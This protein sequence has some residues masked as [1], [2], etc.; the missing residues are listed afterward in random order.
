M[1]RKPWKSWHQRDCLTR[2]KWNAND[3]V[4]NTNKWPCLIRPHTLMNGVLISGAKIQYMWY[5]LVRPHVAK[6]RASVWSYR[7]NSNL[8][9]ILGDL[10]RKGQ[11]VIFIELSTEN[12]FCGEPDQWPGNEEVTPKVHHKFLWNS[13]GDFL[14]RRQTASPSKLSLV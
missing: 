11:H 10:R 14:W 7:Q 9:R 8:Q 5:C 2:L 3:M 1:T 4:D 13:L 12:W 6:W